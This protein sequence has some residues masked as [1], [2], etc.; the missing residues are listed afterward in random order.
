MG[1]AD[2]LSALGM[3][4]ERM[5][6]LEGARACHEAS[7][8]NRMEREDQM[9][10]GESLHNLASIDAREGRLDRARARYAKCLSIRKELGDRLGI[11]EALESF[12]L[13]ETEAG[14][15]RRAA[16]LLGTAAAVRA[17][18]EAGT[19]PARVA[20]VEGAISRLRE[21]LG[22]AVFEEEWLR[23]RWMSLDQAVE[24]FVSGLDSGHQG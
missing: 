2:S 18:I 22:G 12:G 14:E 24:L 15:Y 10:I 13:L 23:G 11:T 21:A 16:G 5:G 17:E 8:A 7:L 20:Q 6:D 3:V 1:I 4:A 19:P 9:G